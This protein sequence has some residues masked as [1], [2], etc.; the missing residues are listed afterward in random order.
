MYLMKYCF[1]QCTMIC[2]FKY[3]NDMMRIIIALKFRYFAIGLEC[4]KENML[5]A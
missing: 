3:C 2:I 5:I 1:K 4:E